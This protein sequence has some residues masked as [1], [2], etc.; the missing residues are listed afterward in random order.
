MTAL[1]PCP[2]SS[3]AKLPLLFNDL[4]VREDTCNFRCTYCLSFEST[5]KHGED[6]NYKQ[7]VTVKREPLVYAPGYAL[8][9]RLDNTIARFEEVADAIILRISGGEILV[10]RNIIDFITQK[11]P[12]YESIQVLTNGYNLDEKMVEALAA[13]G[14]IHV[15]MSL[16]GHTLDLNGYRTDKEWVQERLNTNLNRTVKAGIPTEVGS[17]LTDRNIGRYRSFLDYLLRYEGNI[18]VFPFPVRGNVKQKMWPARAE[19][20]A[21]VDTVIGDYDRYA[22]ILAPR[23]F[24]E[25]LC[26]L[27]TEGHRRMRC[28][29]PAVMIQSFDDGVLTPCPNCWA[30]QLG[31]LA[32]EEP[33]EVIDRVGKD[34]I[35]KVF[36]WPTPR[37][38]FCRQCF[39]SFDMVNLYINGNIDDR[40]IAQNPLL[41]GSRAWE[42]LR[43]TKQMR[44]GEVAHAGQA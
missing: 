27:L 19:I 22:G 20:D 10:I 13:L 40:E 35:Y 16:D 14:N 8:K 4:V 7:Y 41:R 37:F 11:S 28:H 36:L 39:T 2:P 18:M 30:T 43:T 17:V 6:E 42:F 44:M 21:F 33:Q 34:R 24:L 25:E 38:P 23:P 26:F 5:L 12:Q 31:N 9:D 32:E 3:S 1:E 29:V 15:H